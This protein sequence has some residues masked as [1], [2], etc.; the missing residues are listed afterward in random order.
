[1]SLPSHVT[2]LQLE[3]H[4]C[5]SVCVWFLDHSVGLTLLQLIPILCGSS[6][7]SLLYIPETLLKNLIMYEAWDMLLLLP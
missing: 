7:C 3:S 5:R 4:E 1:M 2:T 6:S